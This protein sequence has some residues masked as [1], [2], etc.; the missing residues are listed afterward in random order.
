[1]G[2][3]TL[4]HKITVRSGLGQTMIPERDMRIRDMRVRFHVDLMC[5]LMSI[6]T[7]LRNSVKLSIKRMQLL[8]LN[9]INV[10]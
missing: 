8:P 3:P 5:R 9:S 1:V 4:H 6:F 2:A 10:T 7:R